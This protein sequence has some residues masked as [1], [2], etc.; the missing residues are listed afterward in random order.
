MPAYMNIH[1][2]VS[3]NLG[4]SG[5]EWYM[6]LQQYNVFIAIIKVAIKFD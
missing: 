1:V 5:V 4:S 6:Y 3:I 2:G